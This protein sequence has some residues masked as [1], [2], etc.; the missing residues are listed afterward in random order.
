VTRHFLSGNA[1]DWEPTLAI[2]PNGRVHVMAL[3]RIGPPPEP[4]RPGEQH[5]VTWSSHDGGTTFGPAYPYAYGGG[6]P[7]MVATRSGTLFASWIRIEWDSAGGVDLDRGGLVLATS[8]DDGATWETTLAATMPSGVADKPELA[9]APD[10]QDVYIAFMAR[11]TLDVVASHDGGASWERHTADSTLTGHWPSGIALAPDGDLVVANVKRLGTPQDSL[12]IMALEL[13]RSTDR[14]AGWDGRVVARATR[15]LDVSECVHGPTCP[16]QI[17]YL[18]VA[19][20]EGGHAYAV[21]THGSAGRPYGLE[22]VRSQDGGATWSEPTVLSAAARSVSGD[23]ADHYY[24][25]IAAAGRG[26]VYVAW[27]DDRDGPIGL[28]ARRS[29]DGGL[30]WSADVRLSDPQGLSGIYGEY[31]GIGIDAEGSL[32]VAW[33]DGTGHIGRAGGMGGTWYARWERR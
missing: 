4:G 19:T 12:L 13:L 26:L 28:W 32:H 18:A 15:S 21:Y 2:G 3:R 1:N 22:L 9:V 14:G 20:D 5:I 16:V 11:G 25:M 33:S 24:P 29:D 23:S 27:F 10:G 31:G 30:T 6:D 8:H 17:P 7:R